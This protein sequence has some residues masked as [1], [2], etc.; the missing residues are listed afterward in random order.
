MR[1][2]H[3]KLGVIWSVI[4]KSDDFYYIN[5]FS[6]LQSKLIHGVPINYSG[7]HVYIFVNPA[8]LCSGEVSKHFKTQIYIF[9]ATQEGQVAVAAGTKP[10][11]I[12]CL[13]NFSQQK[14][15]ITSVPCLSFEQKHDDGRPDER[16]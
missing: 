14:P 10:L 1:E 15:P 3:D 9:P 5:T 4:I 6:T 7:L 2:K 11:T 12:L 16:N 13:V 8:S